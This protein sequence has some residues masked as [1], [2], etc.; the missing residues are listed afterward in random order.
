MRKLLLSI[1]ALSSLI[2]CASTPDN[3]ASAAT[4]SEPGVIVTGSNFPHHRRSANA[5]NVSA[6]TPEQIEEMRQSAQNRGVGK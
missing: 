6:L 5:N 1:A 3:S 2:G 4:P